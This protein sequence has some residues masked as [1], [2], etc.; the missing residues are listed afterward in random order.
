MK[1]TDHP[2]SSLNG[3]GVADEV[4]GAALRRVED[5]VGIDTQLGVDGGD[6]VLGREDSLDGRVALAVGRADDL[7]PGVPPPA[8]NTDMA[9]DQ[10]SRPP[11]VLIFGVRPNSPRAITMVDSSKPRRRGPRSVRRL[12]ARKS[13]SVFS[14]R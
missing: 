6:E 3:R 12:C 11:R 14:G 7:S 9:L 1:R 2:I 13:A 5:L 8:N 10:W 4:R